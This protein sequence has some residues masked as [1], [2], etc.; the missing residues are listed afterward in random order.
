MLLIA[1]VDPGVNGAVA[2][3]DFE[4]DKLFDVYPLPNFKIKVG[5]KTRTRLDEEALADLFKGFAMMG[6]KFM[7][8]ENVQG[9]NYG[10]KKQTA[11]GGFQFGYTYGVLRMACLMVGIDHTT[12]S[13]AV[14]KLQEKVPK[15]AHGIVAKADI[16]F[17]EHKKKW[18]G[19]K[20]A[21]LH[22]RADAAFLAR[23]VAR[24]LWP[25]QQPRE[26][27]RTLAKGVAKKVKL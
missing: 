20:G 27:L 1:G 26:G 14:W 7:G 16:E 5:R 4:A 2:L 12:P 19:P 25:A 11:A 6:V 15:D 13:P 18:H 10:G 24:R 23:Y 8:I 21:D 22:D 17:P 3:Y 9:G